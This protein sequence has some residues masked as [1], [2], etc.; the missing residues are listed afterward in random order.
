MK[1][2]TL[3]VLVIVPTGSDLST[4]AEKRGPVVGGAIAVAG[5]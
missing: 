2:P 4:I 1:K 3:I 5:T